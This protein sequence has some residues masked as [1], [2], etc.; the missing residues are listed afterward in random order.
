MTQ[1]INSSSAAS[2]A[3]FGGHGIDIQSMSSYS[4]NAIAVDDWDL[5]LGADLGGGGMLFDDPLAW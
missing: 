4:S 1:A 2:I 5:D 3:S